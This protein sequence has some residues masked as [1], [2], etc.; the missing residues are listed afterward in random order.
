V[1]G[2]HEHWFETP[3]VSFAGHVPQSSVAL[4][5]FEIK[6]HDAPSC[7]QVLGVHADV[8][9]W[10]GPPPP[11][12]CP[13]GQSPQD[14][15]PPHISNADPHC[16]PSCAH[17]RGTQSPPES[18]SG[19]DPSPIGGAPASASWLASVDDSPWTEPSRSPP[20][21]GSAFV[22]SSVDAHD[23]SVSATADIATIPLALA[24]NHPIMQQA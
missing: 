20:G 16:A 5:P 17:V 1:L 22:S 19:T 15:V 12:S 10:L 2:V 23:A 11:H 13:A 8:P 24:P 21:N 6:P 4:H 3:Q 7:A 18:E 14:T 9:H